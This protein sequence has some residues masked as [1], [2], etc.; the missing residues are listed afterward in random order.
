MDFS[1]HST[2]SVTYS[3]MKMKMIFSVTDT[4]MVKKAILK[5]IM[6]INENYGILAIFSCAPGLFLKCNQ[7][8][9]LNSRIFCYLV[10]IDL[11]NSVKLWFL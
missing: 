3:K 4:Y 11:K 6:L 5:I 7:K 1:N 2:V 10:G 9:F 8:H